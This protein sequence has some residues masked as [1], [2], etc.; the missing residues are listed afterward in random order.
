MAYSQP[1]FEGRA[2]YYSSPDLVLPATG[3]VTGVADQADNRRLLLLNRFEFAALG[4]ESQGSASTAATWD[5]PQPT[6]T[7]PPATTEAVC[8]Q[9]L[10]VRGFSTELDGIYTFLSESVSPQQTLSECDDKCVYYRGSDT[11]DVFCFKTVA[12]TSGVTTTCESNS[13]YRVDRVS[14]EANRNNSKVKKKTRKSNKQSKVRA[15]R[16]ENKEDGK[17]KSNLNKRSNT[18]TNSK[19]QG[20]HKGSKVKG[21]KRKRNRNR[22]NRKPLK[23]NNRNNENDKKKKKKRNGRKKKISK[24]SKRNKMDKKAKKGRHGRP[25][26]KKSKNESRK[27]NRRGLKKEKRGSKRMSGKP[28]KKNKN[29]INA[30]RG[31]KKKKRSG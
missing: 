4:D 27:K 5:P 15:R 29:R 20:K 28:K 23:R 7:E 1:G 30:K 12:E 11:N 31:K 9:G 18:K 17:V 10:A 3:T 16:R 14:R 13:S 21:R 24:Q 25:R 2:N 6:A 26:R 19:K 8:C 22:R